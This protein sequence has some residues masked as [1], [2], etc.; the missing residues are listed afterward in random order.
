MLA[1][2]ADA[3]AFAVLRGEDVKVVGVGVAP[4]R[5]GLQPAG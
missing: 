5:V 1:F 4:A 3:G 2:D